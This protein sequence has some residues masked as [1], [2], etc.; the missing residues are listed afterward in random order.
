MYIILYQLCYNLILH[1]N[2]NYTEDH[3]SEYRKKK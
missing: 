2:T 1:T 3:V